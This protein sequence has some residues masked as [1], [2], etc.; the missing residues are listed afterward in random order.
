MPR[1]SRGFVP[2]LI[3]AP[4]HAE[5][6]Q[7]CLQAT[8]QYRIPGFNA[9]LVVFILWKVAHV[10]L[11][12]RGVLE[13]PLPAW[14]VASAAKQFVGVLFLSLLLAGPGLALYLLVSFTIFIIWLCRFRVKEGHWQTP[15]VALVIAVFVAAIFVVGWNVA[16]R[17][18]M[19]PL[20]TYFVYMIPAAGPESEV[21]EELAA[22]PNLDLDR[23]AQAIGQDSGKER[24]LVWR[25]LRERNNSA[26]LRRFRDELSAL[27]DA[28]LA[29]NGSVDGADS[30]QFWLTDSD[31]PWRQMKT[32]GE[33]TAWIDENAPDSPAAAG[34]PPQP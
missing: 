2:I 20:E 32:I 29:P 18:N 16:K 14:T 1:V 34:A 3:L 28:I 27:P 22:D 11:R 13:P 25:I 10:V 6:C 17:A 21:G 26:D 12:S 9:V 15:G 31:V 7:V 30:F 23:I 8:A 5:A 33:L 4:M 19:T 24:R